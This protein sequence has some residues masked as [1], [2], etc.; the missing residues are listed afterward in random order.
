MRFEKL[1]EIAGNRGEMREIVGNGNLR[2]TGN[3]EEMRK[4]A[5]CEKQK[6]AGI[7]WE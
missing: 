7:L 3:C 2:E 1:W 4:I 5:G 6:I